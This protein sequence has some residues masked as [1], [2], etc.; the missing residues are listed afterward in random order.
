MR[1]WIAIGAALVLLLGGVYL[2]SP[3]YA[4][5][6]LRAAARDADTDKLEDSVDFPAVRESLKSQMSAAMMTKMQ[7]DPEMRDNPFAGLGAMMIPTIIDRMIDSFVTP[8]GIA[9]MM[10]GQKPTDAVKAD[11][12]PDVESSSAYVGLDRFR[13]RLHNK[14]SDEEGPSFLLERR[15]FATWKLIRVEMPA[16]LFEDKN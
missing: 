12:N 16:D 2:G 13:V 11:E 8:D 4:I 6:S 10:R 5:H 7:N 1:K 15:G 9:A 14:A 3:Y